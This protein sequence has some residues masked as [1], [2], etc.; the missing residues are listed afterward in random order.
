MSFLQ[1]PGGVG[2]SNGHWANAWLILLNIL[3]RF[4]GGRAYY[5]KVGS[6]TIDYLAAPEEANPFARGVA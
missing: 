2:L 1:E 6:N 3:A 5:K 4:V